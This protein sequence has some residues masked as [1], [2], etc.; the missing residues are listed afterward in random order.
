MQK[1]IIALLSAAVLVLSMSACGEAD[2]QPD[3]TVPE[4]VQTSRFEPQGDIALPNERPQTQ[5]AQGATSAAT[6]ANTTNRP[7]NAEKI[8]PLFRSMV[9]ERVR[10]GTYTVRFKQSGMSVITS[11]SG[12]DSA[13]ESN[14]AGLLQ[15]T[16]INKDGRYY[17]L[18]PTTKKYVEL[19]DED[20]KEQANAFGD[21]MVELDDLVLQ[22]SGAETLGGKKYNTETYDE[23]SRGTVTY[24]FDDTGLRKARVVKDGKTSMVDTFEVVTGV[25]AS[26]FE[27]PAGYTLVSDPGQ[28]FA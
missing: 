22:S 1:R 12:N 18:V 28:L 3:T 19:S 20:Y 8:G 9:R 7:S 21:S 27:I 6:S 11:V 26:V 5:T 4:A 23:G 13:L 17:M 2:K 24:F 16:L 10:T 25:D 15:F 14:A